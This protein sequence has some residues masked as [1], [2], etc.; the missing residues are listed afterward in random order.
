MFNVMT[1]KEEDIDAP[2]KREKFTISVIGCGRMGLPTACLFV[3]VGFKVIGVDT[4][5]A[6]VDLLRKGRAPFVEPGLKALVKKHT[7]QKSF[8]ATNDAKEAASTSDVILFVV[9]TSI[10]PKNRPDYSYVE[11]ACKEVGMGLRPGSLV[12]FK[13]TAGPGVT[14]TLVKETLENVSGLKAGTDFG[15]AYSPIRASR[16][17]V[18]QDIAAYPR[19]VAA[20]DEQSLRAASL[21]LRTIIKAEVIKVGDMKTAEAI[22]LFEN[23]YRDVNIAL[24]NELARFCEKAGIDF[25][26]VQ[27]AANTQPHCHLLVPG[28]VS[29]HIPTDSY[30]LIEEEE[31]VNAKPRIVTLA[32]KTNDEMLNHT[33]H[34]TRDALRQCGKTMRRAKISVFGVS[35][36]PNVK[37]PRGSSIKRLVNKLGKKGA[38]VRV[39]DPLFS[40]KELE[41]LG[42]PAERTLTKSVQGVDC[43]LIAVGHN[44]FRRLNLRRIKFLVKKPA[45]IIDMGHVIDPA[46]AEKEGFVYRGVGRGVWSR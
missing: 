15:L 25:I 38:T 9:P 8:T 13:S 43:L 35:Y 21:I 39:Y 19:V 22:K 4:N 6:V 2:E 16:G 17:R 45:A 31:N 32:R 10:G 14:E 40:Q 7:E 41:E 27:K 33:L 29:G 37:E 5:P 46:K 23:V 24:A 30:L 28:I 3:E 11:K 34:L 26:E 20:V 1:L 44:R 12:I 18:L 42:Y 36:R